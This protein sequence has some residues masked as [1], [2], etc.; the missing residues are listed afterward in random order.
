MYECTRD[1]T[2]PCIAHAHAFAHDLSLTS[3]QHA[4]WKHAAYML[5]SAKARILSSVASSKRLSTN[6]RPH[7]V[8]VQPIERSGEKGMH[9]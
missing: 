4:Q 5:F 2:R 7:L 1:T 9:R 6:T 3:K 8:G